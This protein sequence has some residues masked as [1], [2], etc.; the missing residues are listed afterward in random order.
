VT[1]GAHGG[2]RLGNAPR[3]GAGIGARAAARDPDAAG[4]YNGDV[5]R[6]VRVASLGEI[7]IGQGKTVEVDGRSIAVFHAG[8]GRYHALSGVCPHEDGPLGDGILV[9]ETAVCPWHGF[10]FHVRTGACGVSPDLWVSVYP[11]RVEGADLVVEL[12]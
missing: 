1:Q 10:D 4:P 2:F 12:P 7:P 8:E 3:Q 6:S 9:D 11:V 5:P